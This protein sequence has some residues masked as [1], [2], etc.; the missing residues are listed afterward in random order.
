MGD[1][2]ELME[3]LR[4]VGS[5]NIWRP[6]Y[7]PGNRLL[8]D[9]I[10]NLGNGLPKDLQKIDFKDKKVADLGCNFGYYTFIVNKAGAGH[11]TGI[12]IDRQIIRGCRILKRMFRVD[13]VSF[14][15][16]DIAALD[17][18]GA[19]DIGMMIDFIGKTM[20]TTGIFREYLNVLER[21][22]KKE[23]ILSIKPVYHIK[24][25]LSSD[26][27]G[28]TEKY[29]G[30]Y[31][32]KNSFFTIDYVRDRFSNKWDMEIVSPKKGSEDAEKETLYFIRK[33]SLDN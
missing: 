28:L 2:Q 30:D 26:F 22:S 27:Q 11:V 12:D 6:V 16:T 7:A 25:H 15:A 4:Q 8:A 10:G 3:I 20:V 14:L 1:L 32:R 31:I 24:K 23:M 9:G 21:L 19:F 13:N 5:E 33:N 29:P 17:G 18:I